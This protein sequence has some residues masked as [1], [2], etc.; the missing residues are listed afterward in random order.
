MSFGRWWKIGILCLLAFLCAP[1][2]EARTIVHTKRANKAK[3][4]TEAADRFRHDLQ[5]LFPFVRDG[6]LHL[7]T[8]K[9]SAHLLALSKSL[10]LSTPP[11]WAF[12]VCWP[13]RR[14][15]ILRLDASPETVRQTL[16]HEIVHLEFGSGLS[17]AQT[18]LWF[19]EGVA[20]LLERGLDAKR[21]PLTKQQRGWGRAIAL[22]E[23]TDRFPHWGAKAERAYAQSEAMVWFLYDER[24]RVDFIKFLSALH[25]PDARFETAFEHAYGYTVQ[26]FEGRF[27]EKSQ[28]ARWWHE[29]FRDSTLLGFAGLLLIV[30][31]VRS[32][33]KQ[34][35]K[36]ARL[37]DIEEL[38]Q[39]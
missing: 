14:V 37:R 12:G 18:P 9:D 3:T 1:T 36:L 23:L 5:Q 17:R 19:S 22:T 21:P 4:L 2:I 32:R 13:S 39:E 15:I 24:G 10:S 30:A 33:R 6:D 20:Q 38:E 16:L 8:A 27:L 31:A 28:F 29:L 34:R 11:S 25:N 7:Y 26:E 35:Q